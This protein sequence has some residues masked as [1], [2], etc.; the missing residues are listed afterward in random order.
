MYVCVHACVLVCIYLCVCVCVC[1]T[2]ANY[3]CVNGGTLEH[4]VTLKWVLPLSYYLVIIPSASLLSITFSIASWIRPF[5][6]LGISSRI[7]AL[8][9]QGLFESD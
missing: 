2:Q 4:A 8:A 3:V 7:F 1:L 9:I 5:F 6:G